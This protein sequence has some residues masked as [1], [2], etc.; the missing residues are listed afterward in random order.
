MIRILRVSPFDPGPRALL[1]ASH[2]LM[3]RL[4]TPEQ[5]NFLGLEELAAPHVRLFAAME[6][7]SALG[8]AALAIHEGYGEVKS[9]FT[10]EAARGRGVGRAL[11]ARLEDVA[12]EEGL[13]LLRLETGHELAEAM[14]LYA[15]TGYVQRGPFGPYA[16]NGSSVFM[17]KALAPDGQS[18]LS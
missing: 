17:E 14:R 13:P 1:E 10:A 16:E 5:N 11:L 2:A 8:T 4:Y 15:R 7:E 6:G 9:L 12:A 3:R 18:A